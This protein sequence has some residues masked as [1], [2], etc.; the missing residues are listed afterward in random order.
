MRPLRVPAGC[1]TVAPRAAPGRLGA[2]RRAPGS[3]L[4]SAHS[5]YTVSSRGL[6]G[7]PREADRTHRGGPAGPQ[8][9]G[10][11]RRAWHRWCARR[12]RAKG[13]GRGRAPG[14]TANAPAAWRARA[15]ARAPRWPRSLTRAHQRLGHRHGPRARQLRGDEGALVEAARRGRGGA[16]AAP[17]RGRRPPAAPGRSRRSTAAR[18]AAS[19]RRR[20]S[21]RAA[22]RARG[23]DRS[24][25]PPAAPAV[26]GPGRRRSGHGNGDGRAAP[27]AP[28]RRQRLEGGPAA[29]ARG[30][31]GQTARRARRAA[32]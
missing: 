2:L 29:G 6:A 17:A 8:G 12:P 22:H 30:R 28:G 24:R 20:S 3:G 31:A 32:G 18:T 26:S 14:R 4:S 19:A 5:A 16:R 9:R 7:D 23:P 25:R 11:S 10:R 1:K 13:R 21:F 15:P 27:A